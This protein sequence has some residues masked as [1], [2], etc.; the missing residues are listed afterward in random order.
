VTEEDVEREG[1]AS[2][3]QRSVVPPARVAQFR[4]AREARQERLEWRET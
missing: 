2:T 1:S 4:G 3:T